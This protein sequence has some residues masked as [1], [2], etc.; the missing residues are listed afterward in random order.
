MEI[1]KKR[2]NDG[3]TQC[4]AKK[5]K[6]HRQ[7]KK[8]QRQP[9]T[10]SKKAATERQRWRQRDRRE[11]RKERQEKEAEIRRVRE[12]LVLFLQVASMVFHS[13]KLIY[14]IYFVAARI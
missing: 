5:Q 6:R 1:T 3:E 11:R 4:G 8:K 12:E 14:Y 9:T 7:G 13:A 2:S 10:R